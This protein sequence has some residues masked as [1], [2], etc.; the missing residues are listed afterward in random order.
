MPVI[1]QWTKKYKGVIN[2]ADIINEIV[3]HP[4]FVENEELYLT[5]EISQQVFNKRIE[6]SILDEP[7]S[8]L[9]GKRP[10]S[11]HLWVFS[12]DDKMSKIGQ[13]FSQ[14]THRALIKREEK[15][16][17][18]CIFSQTDLVRFL[19]LHLTDHQIQPI[20][21]LTLEE[22][23]L[24]VGG[25]HVVSVSP[26][27]TA[28]TAF[29]KLLSSQWTTTS[30]FI[31]PRHTWDLSALPITQNGRLVGTISQSDLRGL[32]SDNFHLLMLP[33]LEFLKTGGLIEKRSTISVT[34][35]TT[36][37]AT[38]MKVSENKVHRA[39]ILDQGEL[40]G[41][42]SLTDIISRFTPYDFS[43]L[44]YYQRSRL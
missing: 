39:W 1:S 26:S 27:D 18:P 41:V 24:A 8:M 23:G 12:P 38:I 17:G 42:V 13:Y 37:A 35:T 4:A 30:D 2:I 9:V 32:N 29:R 10:E 20:V 3:F 19:R 43:F 25:R 22:T 16:G 7:I 28:L 6:E 15:S 36:L 33:V 14:G 40:V 5:G 34:P 21:K 11:R 44:S 31:K